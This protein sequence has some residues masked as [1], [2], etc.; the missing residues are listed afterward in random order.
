M[1]SES[2]DL[3]FRLHDVQ[4]GTSR[5]KAQIPD[6]TSA[7]RGIWFAQQ[8]NPTNPTYNIAEYLEI[9]GPL[10][11]MLFE[12]ALRQVVA[13]AETLHFT[14]ADDGQGPQ[15]K[16]SPQDEWRLP[17]ID[18]VAEADP[19]AAAEAWMRA[20]LARPLDLSQGP[21]F[22]F[23]LFRAAPDWF[24]F[25]HRYHHII[26]DGAA[27]ALI[28]QRL[29]EIY[30]ALVTGQPSG[31]SW[32]G[33]LCEL[34]AA[35]DTRADATRA[36][37]PP[38][39]SAAL[40]LADV[41][42]DLRT[43]GV[44]PEEITQAPL[45]Q[46]ER[47]VGRLRTHMQALQDYSVPAATLPTCLFAAQDTNIGDPWHGWGEVLQDPRHRRIAVPGNHQS[48]MGRHRA[49]LGRAI[50]QALFEARGERSDAA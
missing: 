20:D 47:L 24:L 23:A 41:L 42:R 25:Y 1:R 17:I 31:P 16:L 4:N 32:F 37:R 3:L 11:P 12:R 40:P 6:L 29:A 18:C 44:G 15:Q 21:L 48:I 50:M 43:K 27:R 30:S 7:Q 5:K 49:A 36:S 39:R 28:V 8:L 33:G 10:E 9:H 46:I 19:Q 14:F 45:E 26:S 13:E 35:R 22:S 38:G 34:A 2:G